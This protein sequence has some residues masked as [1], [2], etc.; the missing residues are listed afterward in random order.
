MRESGMELYIACVVYLAQVG[1]VFAVSSL[2]SAANLSG[3]Y[4]GHRE[5]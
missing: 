5:S 3:R 4:Y 2:V 1:E